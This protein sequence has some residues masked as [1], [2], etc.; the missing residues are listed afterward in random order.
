M[1]KKD[2][3]LDTGYTLYEIVEDYLVNNKVIHPNIENRIVRV[4]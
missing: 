3:V 2:Q 4:N 1:L